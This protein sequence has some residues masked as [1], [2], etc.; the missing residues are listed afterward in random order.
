MKFYESGNKDNPVILLIPGTCC[1]YSLFDKVKPLL[2][3]RF[4]V[5]VVSFDGFDENENT[6]YIS[7]DDETI[8][9][10]N[11][12]KDNFN[13]HIKCIYGCSLGGSFAAYLVQRGNINVDH[14]IIGSSDFDDD[15]KLMAT[16]K[17]KI[18]TPIMYKMINTGKLPNFMNKK[19]EKIKV[20]DPKK[21]EETNE[22]LKSF[23]SP[24]LQGKVSK[25]SIYNQ[26]VSD[27]TTHLK[28][29]IHKEGTIIHV[30]YATKMG[31]QYEDRYKKYL[32]NPDIRRQDM[33]HESFFFTCPRE[34]TNEV[35]DCVFGIKK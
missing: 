4:Y 34:W 14:I 8:K 19:M 25:A 33:S 27:L 29:G 23:M 28:E 12:I 16:I 13:N 1:H 11:Y 21:Y 30:F 6:T 3:E 15:N 9:I 31:P 35:F 18:I 17:G 32:K 10:E 26:F 7:M 24:A 2:E 5:V 22:F 20:E